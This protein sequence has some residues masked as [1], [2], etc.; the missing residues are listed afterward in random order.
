M[1]GTNED[2]WYEW[3]GLCSQQRKVG[4]TT[5]HINS[6]TSNQSSGSKLGVSH[7]CLVYCL[8]VNVLLNQIFNSIIAEKTK[9]II[10]SNISQTNYIEVYS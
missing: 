5:G 7:K 8:R 2:E 4:F 9:N 1:N 6:D 10:Y 3:M